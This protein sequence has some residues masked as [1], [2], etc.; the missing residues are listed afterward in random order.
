MILKARI[1]IDGTFFARCIVSEVDDF[2]D[3]LEL[4]GLDFSDVTWSIDRLGQNT[5][6]LTT[7]SSDD[8][9]VAS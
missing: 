5:V 7:A 8:D 3:N 4:G 2:I 6:S 9:T 1:L